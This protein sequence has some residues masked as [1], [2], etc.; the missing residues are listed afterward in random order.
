MQLLYRIQAYVLWAGFYLNRVNQLLPLITALWCKGFLVCEMFC[1]GIIF[2]SKSVL[3]QLEIQK[4]SEAVMQKQGIPLISFL[5]NLFQHIHLHIP[6]CLSF[7]LSAGLLQIFPQQY[8]VPTKKQERHF[9]SPHHS[10]SKLSQTLIQ[11]SYMQQFLH[12][13]SFQYQ[14]QLMIGSRPTWGCNV[15]AKGE[16]QRSIQQRQIRGKINKAYIKNIHCL[17]IVCIHTIL[18]S[19]T[20]PTSLRVKRDEN[21]IGKW[22]CISCLIHG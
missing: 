17:H 1:R 11:I 16:S 21:C 20:S 18:P 6:C 7:R 2:L 19:F 4:P 5:R 10:L 9:W 12:H 14:R 3:K 15:T 8:R 13:S 22:I